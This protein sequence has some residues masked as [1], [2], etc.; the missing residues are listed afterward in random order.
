MYLSKSRRNFSELQIAA[1]SQQLVPTD[2]FAQ[3]T[4]NVMSS[5]CATANLTEHL[6]KQNEIMITY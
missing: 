3:T 2:W 4:E 6:G 5:V 1:I